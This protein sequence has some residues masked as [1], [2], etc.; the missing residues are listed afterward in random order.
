MISNGTV[1]EEQRR[2]KFSET[3]EVRVEPLV[4]SSLGLGTILQGVSMKFSI[5]FQFICSQQSPRTPSHCVLSSQL[6]IDHFLTCKCLETQTCILGKGA[7]PFFFCYRQPP[8]QAN[9][10]YARHG[11]CNGTSSLLPGT[12]TGS[13]SPKN[14]TEPVPTTVLGP[15][16]S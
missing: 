15:P 14:S 10:E 12:S 1:G 11:G 4:F 2:Q 7:Q 6:R 3:C 13:E 9:N 8:A 16:S 5:S